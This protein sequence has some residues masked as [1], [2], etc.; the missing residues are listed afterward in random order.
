MKPISIISQSLFDKVRSRFSNLEMGDETGAVVIDPEEARFFDFD[1]VFE[2]N[3]LGRVSISINDPGSLKVYFSQGITENQD[4][5]AKKEWFNFLR[6]MRFFAMRRLLR[7]DT[8]DIAKT[9]LDKNDF[10]HLAKTQAPKEPDMT[11]MNENKKTKRH[12]T[13]SDRPFRG[14]NG[15]FNR[16]DDERHDLDPSDWYKKVG[17]KMYT[18]SI[19]PRQVAQ[20]E[21]EGWHRTKEEARANANPEGV[22]EGLNEFAPDG[23]NGGNDDEGFSPEIA[24]MAQEDG[25]TKGVSLADG[26]TLERAI[27]INHWH[28][29]HGG[30][31][32]QYFTKGF[33]QGRMNKINHDNKQY[34]LNLKLMKDGSIRHG[35]QGVAEGLQE[36][37]WNHKSSKKTSR[38]VA[39]RT[40]VI[41]RHSKP[42]DEE[43]AGS[44]SQH[45]NIKA[46]YIQNADGERFK[47]PFIHTAG[48]FAM[49]QHVDHGGVPHDP[50]GQAIVQMSEEIAKLGEFHRKIH[51]A[52]LHQ[53][54][55][56]ITER[57]MIRMNELKSQIVA[58]GKKQNYQNWMETFNS[59]SMMNP[60]MEELD[61][62]TMEQYKQ[63]FTQTNFQEELTAYF[64]L[65]HRIMGETNNIDIADYVEEALVDDSNAATESFDISMGQ[66]SHGKSRPNEQFSEWAEAVEQGKLAT[67]QIAELKQAISELP[68]GEN[69]PELKLGPAGT[70][71]IEFFQGLGLDDND[72]EEK[73]KDMA[74]V[75]SESDALE[76]FKIW[77]N[78]DYP[79]LAVA[80]GI[81]DTDTGNEEPAS[82][83]QQPAPEAPVEP[84]QP[85][86][87][88]D[89]M[90]MHKGAMPTKESVVK[91]VAKLVKSRYNKDNPEVGPFNGK[92]NIA[93][94]VKKKCA[95]M[96]GEEVGEQAEGLAMQFMEKLSR[97]WEANHGPVQ[98]DGL[99]RLKELLNN[100]KAKVE[101]IG[102]ITDNGHAPGNNIMPAEEGILDKAK[103][104]GKKILDKVAPGD[105]ELLKRLEK[106]TG[107]KRPN[108]YNKPEQKED[109][110]FESIMKLAGISEGDGPKKISKK[111]VDN[112]QKKH[113]AKLTGREVN[114]QEQDKNK[115]K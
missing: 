89:E 54:A 40:E 115:K 24:K 113:D 108:M 7:F 83:D 14:V 48:A 27:T 36:G 32:K 28:S 51:R 34:N 56:G 73:L 4:E 74:N 52:T 20:A 104:F 86:A 13:E 97:E 35:Q 62:V 37:R 105:D 65:L 5:P 50:A 12:V 100:V 15:A 46:I 42:V 21:R 80:L 6:E 107:G 31:Y 112:F 57:A 29:Q 3:N 67:D 11:T 16:G 76:V 82:A 19:Y 78:T 43:Y 59:D 30:M 18:A 90:D 61:D 109:A 58:L 95:E 41:V 110:E 49:A 69:G 2:G 10:Q 72:L 33:K 8:R 9:N 23:F 94:D 114:R 39:G 98:D 106:D 47:Y 77:C 22:A 101:G 103:E 17:T 63:K 55:S 38:A 84:E 91:E 102:D 66:A 85:T 93:L 88:N 99:A 60:S 64:P 53:D 25:F 96:F 71:A 44:R 45:K 68:Q 87:E 70:T 1:F 111:E 92:E 75:D 79:E 26:A 81:S